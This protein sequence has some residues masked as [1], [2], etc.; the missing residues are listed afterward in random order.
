MTTFALLQDGDD[1]ARG[2]RQKR[3]RFIDDTAAV[4]DEDEEEEEE[5]GARLT[6]GVL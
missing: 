6:L 2:K 4:A 1:A 5:V 3:S